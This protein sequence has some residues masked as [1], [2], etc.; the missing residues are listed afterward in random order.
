MVRTALFAAA[1]MLAPMISHAAI[2]EAPAEPCVTISSDLRAIRDSG[3][4]IETTVFQGIE[5]RHLLSVLRELGAPEADTWGKATAVILMVGGP[6]APPA[7]L[8]FADASGC[9]FTA[10]ATDHNGAAALVAKMGTGA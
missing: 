1:L 9:I 6:E 8:K 3:A 2:G 4:P 7:L 10:L 5:A